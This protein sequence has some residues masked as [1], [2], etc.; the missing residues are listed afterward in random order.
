MPSVL[1]QLARTAAIVI[2]LTAASTAEA[3]DQ[4]NRASDRNFEDTVQ[5]LQWAFGGYGLTTVTALDF[6]QVLKNMKVQTGRAVMFE[7]M[8]REW[9]KTLLRE[10][11]ALGWVLPL[12]VYVFEQPDGS[13]MVSY[14]RPGAMLETHQS[15]AVRALG[16]L[17]DEKLQAVVAPATIKPKEPRE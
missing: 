9:A 11:L 8:R 2:A 12:R 17:L 14:S 4:V 16:R 1:T 5:Q 3:T 6:Q 13:T 15:E 10:D 7:V